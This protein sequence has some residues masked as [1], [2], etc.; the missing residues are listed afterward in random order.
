MLNVTNILL[1]RYALW[2]KEITEC[3][4]MKMDHI[5]ERCPGVLYINDDLC[6]HNLTQ[7]IYKLLREGPQCQPTQHNAG[8]HQ[9]WSCIQ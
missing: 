6:I 4:Q 8:S 1:Q 3:F 7:N 2:F 5:I 9:Q